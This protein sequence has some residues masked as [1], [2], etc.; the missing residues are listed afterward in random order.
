MQELLQNLFTTGLFIP[1]GHCYLWKPGLVWLHLVSD[2]A[3]A[4][5]YYSIPV[6]LV[7]FV[8]K[9]VDLPFNWIFLLFSTFIVACGTT[10]LMA[11]WTLWH[12]TYWLSGALKAITASVSLCTALLLLPLIP[13]VLTLPSPTQLEAANL[14]LQQQISDRQRVEAAL[15]ESEERFRSAFDSAAIG[16]ALVALDGRWLKVNR[17]LCEIVG[18]SEQEILGTTFQAITHPDDLDIDLDYVRQLLEGKI[19]SFE[20]EKRYFH[21]LGHVVWILLSG[22]LLRDA[23]GKP[24]YFIGQ[25]QDI[26]L[27]KQTEEALRESEERWQL[28]LRGNNDGIWDWNVRTNEVFFSSRWKEMLGFEDHE[29]SNHIDEWASRVHPDDLGW[30]TQ[31]IQDHFAKKTPFY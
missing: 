2:F 10:H 21:K 9:R 20:M 29:I 22:S 5:A 11:V 27:R 1:H 18:Y 13:K 25:V 8:R 19:R 7:Y 15:Q 26:T 31:V 6:T 4:L 24:L 16:K 28:A 3:I 23:E 30:V 14:Q 12:P 17:A